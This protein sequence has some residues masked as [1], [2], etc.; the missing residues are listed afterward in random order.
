MGR[1]HQV[2]GDIAGRQQL[3]E[4]GHFGMGLR[5][6]E[7]ANGQGRRQE[8]LPLDL[9]ACRIERGIVALGDARKRLPDG[10]PR[11][12]LEDHQAPGRKLAV[13][14]NPG[15]NGQKGA[16]LLGAGTGLAQEGRSDGTAG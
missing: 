1:M 7:H 11:V 2:E 12:P 14:G 3:L 16:K 8:A 5:G 15:G 13:I 4:L 10:A 9:E 6:G